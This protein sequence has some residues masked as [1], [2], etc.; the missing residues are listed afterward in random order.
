MHK[1]HRRTL[2]Q[3]GT[4]TPSRHIAQYAQY[5]E[6]GRQMIRRAM[7]RWCSQISVAFLRGI[8]GYGTMYFTL[9]DMYTAPG[10]V[11]ID[12][13]FFILRMVS[14]SLKFTR[15]IVPGSTGFCVTVLQGTCQSEKRNG[16]R[17]AGRSLPKGTA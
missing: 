4:S 3:D 15:N 1:T 6:F 17:E 8:G 7:R 10:T 2:S 14:G 9:A 12:W 16:K 11:L 5:N 13:Q